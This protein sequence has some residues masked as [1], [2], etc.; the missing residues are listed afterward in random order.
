MP[1]LSVLSQFQGASSTF[2]NKSSTN[3]RAFQDTRTVNLF[4]HMKAAFRAKNKYHQMN[5]VCGVILSSIEWN[6]FPRHVLLRCTRLLYRSA[7]RGWWL[8]CCFS[9]LFNHS[10]NRE[11]QKLT[12]C[13]ESL[14]LY[15]YLQC[16]IT[17]AKSRP[18]VVILYLKFFLITGGF[19]TDWPYSSWILK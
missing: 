11:L 12:V 6:D 4:M 2:M 18:T 13:T 15:C 16:C 7:S 10:Q 19:S 8:D 1:H 9:Y 5:R 14:F 3:C 17:C